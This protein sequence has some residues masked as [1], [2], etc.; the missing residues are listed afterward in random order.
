[1]KHGPF[2][3]G[4]ALLSFCTL[5]LEVVETRLL[6]VVTWYHLAFF[7]ISAAMFGMTAGAIWVFAHRER[8]TPETL[9]DDLTW[10]TS[11]FAIATALSLALQVTLA[12]AQVISVTL[13]LVFTELALA[14]AAP[15][16]FSGAAVSLALTRSRFPI[17][18]VYA[19]DLAGAALGC[20]GVLV[21]LRLTDATSTILLIGALAA[22]AALLFARSGSAPRRRHRF[23]PRPAVLLLVLGC[24]GIANGLTRRGIEPIVVK[25]RTELRRAGTAF[26]RWN[27]Y[28]RV[29]VYDPVN[30][31]PHLWGPSPRT[32][33]VPVEQVWMN[34]DGEAAT[35]MF[36][37]DGDV[38]RVGYLRYDV[39]NLAYFVRSS[40][41]AAIIGVGSGRDVLS[42]WVFG[43]RDITGVEFNP[44]FLDLLTRRE[45]FA[46][47]A[48][49]A[50]LPNVRF[51]EDEARS[52]ATRTCERFDVLQMSMIDTWAAT[53]AGAFSLSE[54][55]L[56]TVGGWTTFLQRLAPDG[57]FSVSRWYAP[58][59]VNETGR[60]V[61]LSTATLLAAGVAEPRLHLFVAACGHIATL[62]LFRSPLLPEEIAML[63][64]AC[65]EY[66]YIV[67]LSPD[68]EP[69]SPVLARI[70]A[71]RS[72][73]ELWQSTR[74]LSLD[75][76]PP[77]DD[78]PFFFNLLPLS[79]PQAAIRYLA[80]GTG[81]IQ[82]NV[83]ATLTLLTILFISLVLVVTTIVLPLRPALRQVGRTLVAG[84][85]A[86]FG[87]LGLGFMFVEMGLL[88]RCTL[89]LGHP[90]YSLSVVL[91][92]LIL[93]TGVGSWVSEALPL[94]TCGRFAI[95][96]VALAAYVGSLRFWLSDCF[97]TFETSGTF[98]RCALAAAVIAPAGLMMGFGFPTGMR[99]VSA[100]DERPTTWF[101]GVNGAAGVL[102][103]VLAV[104]ISIGSGI[105]TTLLLGALCYLA[106]IPA[107]AVIDF[108]GTP[109]RDAVR[110]A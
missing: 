74:G 66:G 26:E 54:N 46:S 64:S 34:I 94:R 6:S 98:V 11:G 103:S 105:S 18:Q 99:L 76:T 97:Q 83:I 72:A 48:G 60:M 70:V 107:A 12:A 95:W 1:M 29:L 100:H 109:H 47:F 78:R 92:S 58:G 51:V 79:R 21:A 14:M 23:V 63:R 50:H 84:G 75:L 82:G 24:I 108:T 71:A 59:E 38:E 42:A 40:G 4:L 56:Y 85:T 90:V 77:T 81:V 55:G 36:R 13:V 3:V 104:V 57:V 37:F 62:L 28:S 8:F 73:R 110:D 96:A 2:Y 32:P 68:Q 43:F 39:T 10:L 30:L 80:V 16:F 53:G 35:V 45:P 31:P 49:L 87:L 22:G 102:A 91:F 65:Q 93:T 52:W 41:R 9:S 101:W 88:Q 86:Y 25:D 15:F 7:V 20:L 27:S 33:M 61:S 17:G 5:M 19:S 106:L 67:V 44:I 69:T 89:F